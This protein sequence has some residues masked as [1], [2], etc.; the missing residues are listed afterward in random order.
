MKNLITSTIII[1]LAYSP[2]SLASPDQ[3]SADRL[4]RLQSENSLVRRD[5]SRELYGSGQQ[6]E[7]ALNAIASLLDEQLSEITSKKDPRAD[8]AAWHTK[9]LAASGNMDYL[10]L[11][12][13]AIKSPVRSIARHGR[14]AQE[15][16]MATARTGKPM[17]LHNNIRIISETQAEKCKYVAQNTCKTGRSADAC[18][19]DHKVNA[20][21]A[22]GDSMHI[23]NSSHQSGALTLFG[24]SVTM[25]ASYYDCRNNL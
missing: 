17:M 16:L 20:V 15:T 11:I 23:L 5:V 6:D 14:G 12:E 4:Q 22:G 24:G 13:R 3:A 25:V 2:I 10:P 9:A 1:L 19:E 18:I 8:E 7:E 21:R